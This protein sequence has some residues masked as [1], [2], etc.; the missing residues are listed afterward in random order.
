MPTY[1]YNCEQCGTMEIF[2]GI[3]EDAHKVCP[4]CGKKGLERLISGGAA[5]IIKGRQMNQYNDVKFAKYW[6]DQNGVRHKVGQGDGH[7]NSPTV[8]KRQIASPAKVQA[9][10]HRD[11]KRS[12]K[13]RS[14]ESYQRYIQNVRRATGK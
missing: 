2:H 10:I 13:Q 4:E 11:R 1:E 3:K 14:N 12:A 5:V 8:P 7:S 6:R 9:R